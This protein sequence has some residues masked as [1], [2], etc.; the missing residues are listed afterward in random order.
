MARGQAEAGLALTA[1]GGGWEPA[2]LTEQ[3]ISKLQLAPPLHTLF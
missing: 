3:I 2:R 1:A